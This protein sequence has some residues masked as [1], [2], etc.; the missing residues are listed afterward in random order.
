MAERLVKQQII[1]LSVHTIFQP[2][3]AFFSL[4]VSNWSHVTILI[5]QIG[6]ESVW[7]Y[8]FIYN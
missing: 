3:I 2:S 6:A 5:F 4:P 1:L 8:V 7:V